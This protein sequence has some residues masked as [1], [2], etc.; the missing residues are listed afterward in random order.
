MPKTSNTWIFDIYPESNPPE[1]VHAELAKYAKQMVYCRSMIHDQD[2][3]KDGY[4]KKAHI[5][6]MLCFNGQKQYNTVK[7]M[8]EPMGISHIEEAY[9]RQGTWDYYPHTGDSDKVK[10]KAVYP[11]DITSDPLNFAHRYISGDLAVIDTETSY[12]KRRREKKEKLNNTRKILGIVREKKYTEF[13]QLADEIAESD[14][15]DLLELFVGKAYFYDRYISSKRYSKDY[16]AQ[17]RHKENRIDDL[18][19]DIRK[20]KDQIE[21]LIDENK[22][23]RDAI[24]TLLPQHGESGETIY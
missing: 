2:P 5:H 4:T 18:E 22:Y 16:E 3:D 12:Q 1:L 13:W 7:S 24:A 19:R 9:S 15:D 17:I 6:Y 23:L 11:E 21:D 10:G 14:N 20:Q 8:L